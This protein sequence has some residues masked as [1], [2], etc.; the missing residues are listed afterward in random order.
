MMN[1]YIDAML[2]LNK[3]TSTLEKYKMRCLMEAFKEGH[4]RGLLS[5][6]H[7]IA[8]TEIFAKYKSGVYLDEEILPIST[9]K[10]NSV[11][12]YV[13]W[14]ALHSTNNCESKFYQ[15]FRLAISKFTPEET[16]PL[17]TMA[18]EFYQ[19]NYEKHAK[20]LQDLFKEVCHHRCPAFGIF[21]VKY[22]DWCFS[23]LGMEKLRTQYDTL[24]KI[25][26]PCLE[27]H[28]RMAQIESS[29][30]RFSFYEQNLY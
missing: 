27:L 2:K 18:L 12:L 19:T 26:P 8:L 9:G 20:T 16:V 21:R 3:D 1:M 6:A 17:W 25:P 22:L 10:Y 28:H 11:Q 5:E 23:N 15:I 14:L 13:L 4:E 24:T 29:A 7:Y 30:V